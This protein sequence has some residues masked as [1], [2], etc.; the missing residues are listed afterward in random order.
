MK[1]WKRFSFILNEI[2]VY[3]L[4]L[5]IFILLF[6]AANILLVS[7]HNNGVSTVYYYIESIYNNGISLYTR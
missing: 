4:R 2:E 7:T 3:K 5:P 6:L 1:I